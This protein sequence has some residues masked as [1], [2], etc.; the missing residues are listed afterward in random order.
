[1]NAKFKPEILGELTKPTSK[2]RTTGV[3]PDP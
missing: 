2:V 3:S 1:M